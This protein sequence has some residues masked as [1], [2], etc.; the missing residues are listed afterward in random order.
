MPRKDWSGKVTVLADKEHGLPF[1]T[2]R[3]ATGEFKLIRH[4][5]G[6]RILALGK[7]IPDDW[8]MI[9]VEVQQSV[10]DGCV[11]L[12]LRKVA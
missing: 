3:K 6:S 1:K 11:F 8:T 12:K 9:Q 10:E 4:S 5:G 7:Y 2:R